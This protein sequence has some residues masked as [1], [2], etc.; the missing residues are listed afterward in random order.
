MM[1]SS[2]D[3]QQQQQVTIYEFVSAIV[4]FDLTKKKLHLRFEKKPE[5]LNQQPPPKLNSKKDEFSSFE[6]TSTNFFSSFESHSI[7]THTE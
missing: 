5:F 3:G 7:Y 4:E 2:T 6:N 1:N